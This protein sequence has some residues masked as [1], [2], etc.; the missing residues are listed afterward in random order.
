MLISSTPPVAIARVRGGSRVPK[1]AG[2]VRFYQRRDGVLVV[3]DISGLPG[4]NPAGFFAFHI[5]QGHACTGEDFSNTG[6]HYNPADMPHP[7]HAGDLPP[8]LSCH[9]RA[10]MTVLTDRFR[11]EEIIGHTV[12]IHSS[13]D[14]FHTQPAGNAGTKIACG[15]IR[16]V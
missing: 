12:V 6:V 1:L 16:R 4:N 13:P 14:D 9:G 8:L 11:A 10:H 3:A 2:V 15:A 5:H 7:E